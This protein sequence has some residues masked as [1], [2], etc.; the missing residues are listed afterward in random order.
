M[1]NK[2]VKNGEKNRKKLVKNG[3]KIKKKKLGK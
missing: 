3:K 1:A 2:L